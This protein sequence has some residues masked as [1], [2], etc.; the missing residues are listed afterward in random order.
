MKPMFIMGCLAFALA[1]CSEPPSKLNRIAALQAP[2]A[3]QKSVRPVQYK[4]VIQGYEHRDP[5]DPQDWR[6]SN[7]EQNSGWGIQ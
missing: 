3:P 6:K 2:V 5:T 7:E 1:A 4:P